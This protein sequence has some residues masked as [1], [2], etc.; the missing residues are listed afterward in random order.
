MEAL[1]GGGVVGGAWMWE[2]AAV[3]GVILILAKLGLI[4]FLIKATPHLGRYRRTV[5]IAGTL[6]GIVGATSNG[7]A[8]LS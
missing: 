5:L 2:A 1:F 4:G 6:V 3:T 7:L 8:I